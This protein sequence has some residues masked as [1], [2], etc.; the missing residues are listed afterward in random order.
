MEM[1]KKVIVCVPTYCEPE[2]VT[3]YLESCNFIKYRPFQ[4]IIINAN[5]ADKT[6]KI[7]K[8]EKKLRDYE[9]VEV[10]G[11]NDEFWSATVNRGLRLIAENAKP[12][13]YILIA[14]ID[15]VFDTDIV[16]LL[17]E[18]ALKQGNCQ[19]GA[20][21]TSN[22][23]AISSGVQVKSWLAT[24]T[25]HPYAGVHMKSIP[26]SQLIKVDYLP[27][28][29]MLFPVE[30]LMKVG[31][32]SDKWL[33]HYGADYE[34]SHRLTKAGYTPYIYTGVS[35]K[36]DK[37]NTGKSVYTHQSSF[38]ESI[39]NLMDIKNPSN[40]KFR[41]NFVLL[42]Y[43]VYAIPTAILAYLVRTIIETILD[44]KQIYSLF[45]QKERGFSE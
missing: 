18:Q 28:R 22:D 2:K 5:P 3:K 39:S 16:S 41:I 21:S 42:V 10:C 44:K 1:N 17:L 24:L 30:A 20:I 27:T 9:I 11:Q 38:G 4:L 35:I 14:N 12:E 45:G 34:F 13:D 7:I 29:C 19:M 15:I 40:P 43:P 32:I 23:Y 37:Q 8:Q 31:V 25:S 36:V 26:N 6:S 33:P